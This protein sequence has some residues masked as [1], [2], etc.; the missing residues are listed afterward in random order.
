M[1]HKL[2]TEEMGRMSVEEFR[3][4]EKLPLT[5][6]LDNVRSLNNI[7]SVFRTSDAF[8]VEHIALCGIT[9]T[10]PH[11]EIH[12]TALGAEE[13]VAWSYHEDTAECVRALKEQ[14]YK[15]YAVE[16][17]DDSIKLGTQA[18][19][20]LGL[21]AQA[22]RLHAT[23]T[24]AHLEATRTV[25]HLEATGTVAHPEAG[26]T[27]A[28]P[29]EIPDVRDRGYLPHFENRAIQFITFRLYDSVPKELIEEWKMVLTQESDAEGPSDVARQMHKLVDK[30]ED[31][32]YGQCFLADSRVADMMEQTLRHDDGKKYDL[33][34]YCIM[35]NHVHVMIRV[36]DG[37]S[38]SSILHTWRSY[39]AHEANKI[40]GRSGDFWMKDYYD[41]YIRNAQHYM[42]V[43]QY[44]KDNPAKAG[45][46]AQ[47]SR[48]LEAPPITGLGSMV[49]HINGTQAS[50]LHGLGTQAS[51]L[52][53]TGTVA[54]PEATE[55]VAH[56]EATET[57]AHPEATETVAHPEATGTV[58]HPEA[59]ETVAHPEAT[60]T[61]AHPEAGET[62]AHLAIIL[63][64]EIE[65][66]QEGI[67][68]LCDGC[69]EIPQYGTKHSLNV[70][71]AAAIVIW[72]LFKTM[73]L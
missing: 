20:L 33:I 70:S 16:Q 52:H 3:Q 61:V 46:G 56:P 30:F 19:R 21:G 22:S 59:T 66:V 42:A 32:G 69:L 31:S 55:T 71:C 67:L 27:P 50:R 10:P 34:S 44:I 40:L 26:E 13:S 47:A 12:K 36:H 73:N 28:Y 57:V 48:L 64:N 60:E 43:V 63:G 18:S 6:V 62:L 38:L 58:A 41:R 51:R 9:A 1:T 53:A 25:A 4:S 39:S 37:V 5:V 23:G 49:G 68:P 54:H 45:L 14:G 72:E 29:E 24:V 8:R 35:P 7:G 11:R 15:V 17:V 65:G 2:T